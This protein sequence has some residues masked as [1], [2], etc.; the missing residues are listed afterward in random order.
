MA[1]CPQCSFE[2][3]GS[4]QCPRCGHTF[5]SSNEVSF[6]IDRKAPMSQGHST[7]PGA[8][9]QP[10][11]SEAASNI[12]VMAVSRRA[13]TQTPV[14]VFP[15]ADIPRQGPRQ[16]VQV[17]EARTVGGVP[18]PPSGLLGAIGYAHRARKWQQE[19]DGELADARKAAEDATN[20][21]ED[22]LVAIAERAR[23]PA[24]GMLPYRRPLERLSSM[25]QRMRSLDP[26]LA[27][28]L[29]GLRALVV[30]VDARIAAGEREIAALRMEERRVN[31]Q[32]TATEA[33]I[34]RA[35]AKQSAE[36]MLGGG[37]APGAPG[38]KR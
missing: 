38:S 6:E 10:K 32:L 2:A 36:T 17:E 35:K 12:E 3:G 29:D 27:S 4:L 19:L 7:A 31:D 13:P 15:P 26:Q 9:Y 21:L 23:H 14:S 16:V 11:A 8:E 33:S 34:Y 25:E 18:E 20:A 28:N 30:P 1:R 5:E 24:G 37:Q 22:A